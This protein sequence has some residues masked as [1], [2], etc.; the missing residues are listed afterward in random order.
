L[1]PN[2]SGTHIY[3]LNYCTPDPGAVNWTSS[4]RGLSSFDSIIAGFTSGSGYY[5]RGVLIRN[6]QIGTY[7]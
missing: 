3:A 4:Q 7:N 5:T 6:L 1:A 2:Y